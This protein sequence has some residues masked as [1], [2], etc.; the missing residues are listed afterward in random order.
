MASP[1]F[2]DGAIKT[3]SLVNVLADGVNKSFALLDI[4][5]CTDNLSNGGKKDA[6]HIAQIVMPLIKQM[7]V[8]HV[9]HNK[10]LTGI[11][12]LVFFDGASNV[13]NAGKILRAFNPHIT[14]GHGAAVNMFFSDVYN[15]VPVFQRLSDFAK[16]IHNIFGSVRHSPLAMFKKYSWQHNNCI[17]ILDSSSYQNAGWPESIFPYYKCCGSR[18]P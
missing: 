3:V 7:E 14:I 6:K 2:G 9:M 16:R 15:K 13:Q 11:V 17:S 10:K 4:A 8:E 12:D 5:N 18:M 1:F